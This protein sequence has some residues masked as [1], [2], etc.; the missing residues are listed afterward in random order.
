MLGGLPRGSG[1][2]D[3]GD[4]VTSARVLHRSH[5]AQQGPQ[6]AR[7]DRCALVLAFQDA[8]GQ[9]AL[10][11]VQ[12]H[13]TFFDRAGRDEPVHGHRTLLADAVRAAHGLV[14]G[15]GVPPGV[16]DQHVVCRGQ[17]QAEA[18]GLQADEEEVVLAALEGGD[19]LWEEK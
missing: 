1:A 17:V 8:V 2:K 4:A 12:G 18:A 3:S 10:V 14:F 19:S 11:V 15:G 9:A 6:L 16:D 7:P 5:L 13:D